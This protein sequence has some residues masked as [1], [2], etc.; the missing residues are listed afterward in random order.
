MASSLTNT[1]ARRAILLGLAGAALALAGCQ[2]G[3]QGPPPPSGPLP[4]PALP[5]PPGETPKNGVAVIV[6]ISGSDGPVGTSIA[7]AARL[8]LA[9]TGD[10]TIRLSVYDSAAAGGAAAAANRAIA[11]GNRLILGPL[12]AEDVRAAAPVARRADVPVIAFTNDSSAAGNGVFVMG[13][14]PDQSIN[15]AVAF[16]RGRGSAR[17]AALVPTGLYGQRAAQALL[18]AV[19]RHGGSV[20]AIENFNRTP[21]AAGVAGRNLN[22]RG[23]FDA[24]LIADAGRIAA[25]AGSAI[26]VGPRRIGTELWANDKTLGRTPALRGAWFAAAPDAQFDRMAT[27]YRARY[28]KTPYRLAS[29]GY[30]AVLLAVRSARDW[31]IGRPFPARSL[32]ERDGFGGVDGSFRFGRNGVAERLLE[33]RQVTANGSIVVSPAPAAF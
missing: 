12:L 24:V 4:G 10:K 27:R 7:N 26:K 9:E 28:G 20:A 5:L 11:D 18:G 32:I 31:P 15:R 14:S 17:F 25:A 29:L 6:P 30:D 16:A 33:V 1:Q 3:R 19:R 2:T 8:A 21:A 13:L 22:A 23:A